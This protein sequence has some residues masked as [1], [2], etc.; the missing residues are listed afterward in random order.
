M[1]RRLEDIGV[2]VDPGYGL[3]A[4]AEALLH[5]IATGLDRLAREGEADAIDLGRLPLS[6]GERDRLQ[7]TLGTGEV[8]ATLN[9]DGE[10]HIRETA[11]PGVWWVEHRDARGERIADLIEITRIPPILCTSVDDIGRGA[12]QLR[13]RI[14][15]AHEEAP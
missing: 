2:R 1:T 4:G 3:G 10:S 13:A 8:Q 6:P 7:Q 14:R 11:I 9:V 5:Q 15:R 12:A